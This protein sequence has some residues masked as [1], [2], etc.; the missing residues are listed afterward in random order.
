MVCSLPTVYLGEWRHLPHQDKAYWLVHAM[1]ANYLVYGCDLQM[2]SVIFKKGKQ[3]F[4]CSLSCFWHATYYLFNHD[5][6]IFIVL[7]WISF[8]LLHKQ[9]NELL[10]SNCSE[11]AAPLGPILF[12]DVS[13]FRSPQPSHLVC[14]FKFCTILIPATW[15]SRFDC[16]NKLLWIVRGS[17]ADSW[18]IRDG[19]H[20]THGATVPAG[21][22]SR[23]GLWR[24]LWLEGHREHRPRG[25]APGRQERMVFLLISYLIWLIHLLSLN[26]EDYL[27]SK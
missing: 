21:Y 4:L 23:L 17:G 24:R 26:R 7:V 15:L 3:G 12:F 8:H 25:F 2:N 20:S 9:L 6:P 10:C 13:I 1:I 18:R 19:S 16:T 5:S 22:C 27:T 11:V 14:T